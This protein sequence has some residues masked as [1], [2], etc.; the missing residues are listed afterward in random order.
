MRA[1]VLSGLALAG[2]TA[3]ASAP[4]IEL[5]PTTI[6]V[7]AGESAGSVAIRNASD[8]AVGFRASALSWTNA[9]EQDMR[10]EPT[11]DL[12]VFPATLVIP[13]RDTRRIRIGARFGP[14]AIERSYRLILEEVGLEPSS[15]SSGVTMRMRFSLP[16]FFQ[17]K[18]RRTSVELGAP[19]L[20]RGRVRVTVKNAGRLHV[21]PRAFTIAG[22]DA[23]GARI[24][25]RTLPAWY[26]LAGE[27]RTYE[28]DLTVDECGST[29]SVT[30]D[31]RFLEDGVAVLRKE[32]RA[33]PHAC[34]RP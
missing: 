28:R 27:S 1:H 10:L 29:A 30:A 32:H 20:S 34:E 2:V 16:V 17:P 6:T 5:I 13:P 33:G 25:S 14:V 3:L 31:I 4:S 24:W 15:S 18:N 23:A 12:V 19:D 7:P 21:T 8:T 11:E 26:L 9:G 22:L